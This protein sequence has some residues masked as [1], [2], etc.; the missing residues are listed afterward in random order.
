MGPGGASA[1]IWLVTSTPELWCEFII[2]SNVIIVYAI[3]V[4]HILAYHAWITS[5]SRL[6]AFRSNYAG[7]KQTPS[8]RHSH[9]RDSI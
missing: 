8:L 2:P 9:C 5:L 6:P 3:H 1:M 4:Q 7:D